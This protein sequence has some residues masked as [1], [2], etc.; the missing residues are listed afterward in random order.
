MLP[1]YLI[2]VKS[3][4]SR[5]R[6]SYKRID[7]SDVPETLE[8]RPFYGLELDDEQKKFRDAIW[9]KDKLVII[10]N[11]RAGSGKTLVALG[12]ANLLVQYGLYD[13]IVYL[14]APTEEE[15]QGF[16]PGSLNDKSA[17]YMGPLLDALTTI[18]VSMNS[19]DTLAED[20]GLRDSNAYIQ[21]MPHTFL[22]GK[23]FDR[24]VIV[25]DETQNFYLSELKKSLSRVKDSCKLIIIGHTGQC[26]L[27][28]NPQ[29]S[30]F[31]P[32]LKLF[33][34]KH[35]DRVEIC[36]L[37]TNHRGWISTVADELDTE[38]NISRF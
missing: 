16:L 17:P 11:A 38:I 14:F 31:L 22:R 7:S 5:K 30:G 27:Y 15:K 3:I 18:G 20:V 36:E 19:I 2:G 8:G 9:N 26:D 23:N 25:L 21:F 1:L 32:A 37:H 6:E 4:L 28:R 13:K 29:N 24:S 35:D 12:V 10:C 33:E 34:S